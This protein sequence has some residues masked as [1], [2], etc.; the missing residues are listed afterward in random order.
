MPSS[1]AFPSPYFQ[2]HFDQDVLVGAAYQSYGAGFPDLYFKLVVVV[3]GIRIILID[4]V[5]YRGIDH[6]ADFRKRNC[7]RHGK[8]GFYLRE[9]VAGDLITDIYLSEDINPY[10]QE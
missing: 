3:I 8:A 1:D 6:I 5:F 9:I 4:K 10:N 7:Y 2:W